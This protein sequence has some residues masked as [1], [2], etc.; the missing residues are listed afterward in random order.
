MRP[1]EQ[2]RMRR[3]RDAALEPM[4]APKADTD[5]ARSDVRVRGKADIAQL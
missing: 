2:Q 3:F 1:A 5:I 4:S